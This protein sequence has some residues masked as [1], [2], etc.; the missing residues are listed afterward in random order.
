MK[1]IEQFIGKRVLVVGLAKSG[2]ATAGLLRR[3]G[4]E[5]VVNDAKPLEGNEEAAELQAQGVEVIGGGHPSDLLKRIL[6]LS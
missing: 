5:V 1:N 2:L 6:T 4:A 3:L